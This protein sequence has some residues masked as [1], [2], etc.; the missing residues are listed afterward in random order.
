MLKDIM[1]NGDAFC[2]CPKGHKTIAYNDEIDSW[3]VKD[4]I[5]ALYNT[6]LR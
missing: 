3:T 5:A 4:E 1:D 2:M 6:Y